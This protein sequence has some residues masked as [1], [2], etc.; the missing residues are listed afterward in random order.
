[1]T[2]R[3]RLNAMSALCDRIVNY[4]DNCWR[5]YND[6]D[7]FNRQ[8][9]IYNRLLE[10]HTA[11][12][13]SLTIEQQN[14]L[15]SKG[16]RMISDFLGDSTEA[17]RNITWEGEL[18]MWTTQPTYLYSEITTV[19][20]VRERLARGEI[21][22]DMSADELAQLPDDE[23]IAAL[24]PTENSISGPQAQKAIDF[25]EY[26]AH[27]STR[28]WM[29]AASENPEAPDEDS[30]RACRIVLGTSMPLELMEMVPLM[31]NQHNDDLNLWEA[32]AHVCASCA[33]YHYFDAAVILDTLANTRQGMAEAFN[34]ITSGAIHEPE[35]LKRLQNLAIIEHVK[36]VGAYASLHQASMWLSQHLVCLRVLHYLLDVKILKCSPLRNI[37]TA[38]AH[39]LR[40]LR[41]FNEKTHS[42]L[43]ALKTILE[44]NQKTDK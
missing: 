21:N 38:I 11:Y 5:Y 17:D 40:A 29:T 28:K 20:S 2:P 33:Q 4:R 42:I 13:D 30:A 34:M 23:K 37:D 9:K 26:L 31:L 24:M 19:K 32:C 15:Y 10:L 1:M 25:T 35:Q 41:H 36:C 27:P 8:S 39:A 22:C 3:Q 44:K 12:Y 43:A 16:N 18:L 14:E 7:R 6:V